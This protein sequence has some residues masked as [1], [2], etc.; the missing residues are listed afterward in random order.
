ME[1]ILHDLRYGV[2]SLKAK[3]G[4]TALVVLALGLGIG[5]NTALFT[6]VNSVLLRPLPYERPHE[7]V[8]L[9]LT[10]RAVPL[11]ELN[12]ARS[13]AGVAAFIPR[14]F[15]IPADDGVKNLYG[16]RV[17]ANL[18][19]ILGVQPALGRRFAPGEDH[20]GAQPVAMLSYEYWRQISGSPEIIGK[21]LTLTGETYTVIGV[22]PSDFT[23]Q[24]RDGNIFI[25]Y[26][27]SEGRVVARLKEGVSLAQAEAE[28]AGILL[29]LD[30]PSV[31]EN[32]ERPVRVRLISE[33]FLP[34]DV[35]TLLLWQAAAG[36]VLLIMCSNVGNLVL[37]RA[38][39][40]RR[41]FAIR[42]A[43]GAGRSQILRQLM[44][45]SALLAV[46]GGA[47]GLL[48]AAWS[49]NY[50][51]TWLPANFGRILRGAEGLA[52]D[53]RVLAFT[54][55]ASLLTVLLFGLIPALSALRFD[56]MACLRESAS[57]PARDRQRFGQ[58]LV[59]VEVGL[60]V[61][62]LIGSGLTL[63]SLMGLERQSLGFS[64]DH[65]LRAMV[66]FFPSRYPQPEMRVVAFAGIVERLQ[67]LPGVDTVG[68]LAPQVFPFG[69]PRVRGAVFQIQGRPDVEP[70][71]EVYT[72]NPDYFRSV[73][74]PLLKGRL[75]T[76]ADRLDSAPVA[77]LSEVVAKRYW[78]QEDPIGRL[79]R[80]NASQTDSPWVTVI[81]VVGDVRNPVALDVQPTAY[82]P[83][84]QNPSIGAVV[85][86]RTVTD[87]MTMVETIR[88]ELQAVDPG[89]LSVRVA[90]LEKAVVGYVSPQRFTASV[91]GFFA[92]L[93]LLL[94]AV[95][96][97]GVMRYWVAAR[98]P[99]IGIR[100]ALG[101]QRVD[102]FQLVLGKAAKAV[103][104]GIVIGLGGAWALQRLIT[105][106]LYGVSPTDPLVFALVTL[107]I[108]A[109]ALVAAFV[110]A[111][112]A[113]RID[114]L[115]A[116]KN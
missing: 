90:N 116:L 47:L 70:R 15:M 48:L 12:E 34:N 101:A 58:M 22:L 57:G 104:F 71:A 80:L 21:N 98:I 75:F 43:V 56:V 40:R 82:R 26:P 95:G 27:L 7:L 42:A 87:P 94:A 50:I 115:V 39:G 44:T 74:I 6:V 84:A 83:F 23:L 33:T 36:L 76:D 31:T 91:F 96:V 41:E 16:F 30:P 114:P 109:V 68:L 111:Q 38:T 29:G 35:S 62:L 93:G 67:A 89:G 69:G 59:G 65:V 18:F 107:L 45:E 25:P 32:R 20:A 88:K 100:M 60:A 108:G 66:E 105:S 3:P 72:A 13:F 5:A 63:K 2:R 73:R 28:V 78:G 37:V 112:W 19:S 102:V 52:I 51:S 61:M 85:M 14:G 55:G 11:T 24:V 99:E 92:G 10:R 17:S 103:A 81:G 53:H 46:M 1:R 54:I 97:Y 110:P 4:F 106:Q 49:L 64:P 77:I 113:A 79:V 9:S 86:V 8:E